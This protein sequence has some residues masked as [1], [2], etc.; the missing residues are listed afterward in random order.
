MNWACETNIR[1]NLTFFLRML[2]SKAW[3]PHLEIPEGQL[4]L[5]SDLGRPEFDL[6]ETMND[7]DMLQY[8]V[9]AE[10][11]DAI[12]GWLRSSWRHRHVLD[13]LSRRALMDQTSVSKAMYPEDLDEFEELTGYEEEMRKVIPRT[14]RPRSYTPV[15]QRRSRSPSYSPLR[16]TSRYCSSSRRSR[17]GLL[18][19][20]QG[21]VSLSFPFRLSPATMH[22]L[23]SGLELISK[24]YGVQAIRVEDPEPRPVS[25]STPEHAPAATLVAI[26]P[27]D[28][29][30][31]A[32]IITKQA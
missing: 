10:N 31:W 25:V 23:E 16:R 8:L 3:R 11:R 13:D 17:C 15:R 20:L 9:E 4:A 19:C 14:P 27:E 7:P 12:K 29:S 1:A 21:K 26:P 28:S 24:N 18:R 32:S 22:H 5:I 2:R 6:T 30:P